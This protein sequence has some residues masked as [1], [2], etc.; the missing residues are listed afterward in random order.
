MTSVI[1][2]HEVGPR[3]GGDVDVARLERM[4]R[5]EIRGEVRFD[6][7]SRALY[8]A[9]ASNYR[10][11]PIGVVIPRDD[12]DVEVAVAA[13]R[14]VGAPVLPRGC[15][16]SLAGQCCNVALI[17]DCSKYMT[18]IRQIDPE[19]KVARV[20][21][22]VRRDQLVNETE[23]HHLTFGPDTSTHKYATIGGMMGNNSCGVRSVLAAFSGTG[24]RAS[25]NLASLDVLTYDGLRLR[26]GPTSDAEYERI[27]REGGRKAE[28]YAGLRA[29]RDRYA[30]QIRERIPDIP[31]RVSGFNLDELLPEKGFNLA[32]AVVGSEGTC[33]TILEA[34]VLLIPSPPERVLLVIG[35][36]DVYQ[37]GDHVPIVMEHRPTGCEGI[38]HELLRYMKL[39]Q[40]H[41][42]DIPLLPDGGGWLL[43]EFGGDTQD[44]AAEKAQGLMDALK[45]QQSSPS[46]RLLR[47][48]EEQADLW[49]IR[50]S[51]LGAT[52]FVPDKHDT[53]PG[54]EDSAVPPDR[55][56][57]YLRDLR[58]L[59]DKYGYDASVYGHFGQGCIH[60]RI[61]FDLRSAAG[62]DK[63]KAFTNEAAELVVHK[64]GGS[65]SGEHGDGQARGE[66]L[67]IMYGDELVSAFREFKAIWDPEGKMNPGKVVD[68]FPRDVNLRLGTDYEPWEPETY[69][70]F[71]DDQGSFSRATLRCVGVGK[72]RRHESGTMCPSFQVLH[73][74]EHTTRGRTHL[75][76][77][78]L[79]GETIT[80]GWKSEPVKEALDLCLAC[81]GCKHDCPVNVDMATYKAEFLAHY[82]EGK[83]RPRSAIAFG[84]IFYW[85]RLAALVPQLANLATHA[86]GLRGLAKYVAGVAPER[87]VPAFAPETFKAW[88]RRHQRE[89]GQAAAPR[90]KVILW[91]DTF[92]NHFHPATAAAAVDVL[93]TAGYAVSVP[94]QWLC[95]GR[96][97]YDYG[98]LKLARKLLQDVLEA[99]R[100]DIRAGV[101][102]IGLEPSCAAVFRDEL[103]NLFP[104]DQDARRLAQQTY[105]LSEFLDSQGYQPPQLKADAIVH[106]HCHHRSLLG[107]DGEFAILERMGLDYR[108][109]DDGC[110]G[111]AGSFGFERG[112][113]YDLSVRRGDQ[114]LLPAVRDADDST[115]IV[116][117]GFSCKEQIEQGSRR[118]GLH[119]AQALQLALRDPSGAGRPEERAAKLFTPRAWPSLAR[120]AAAV[121]AGALAA[122][123]A[124]AWAIKRR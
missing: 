124:V 12:S 38:D 40:L 11:T 45:R 94:Q 73:E 72:C 85:A 48:P 5:S 6:S 42:G 115:L 105:T 123:G 37:A 98:M 59:Y 106:A 118:R 93:E 49:E 22:G 74:E 33:V 80:E 69:F 14:H 76:F 71:P 51:G 122:A 8:A 119:L 99:L 103:I 46:M 9:D 63:Y 19:R 18:D 26:L 13:A 86:P 97:L 108:I 7:G 21:P 57:D 82:Y 64:Y 67:P 43:V 2:E 109:P 95:C 102:L 88:F 25:D 101:P 36:P 61:D 75:L 110:C 83:L 54:W 114:Q 62:I 4:L 68:P 31:R 70:Q 60:T 112:D 1:R 121:G 15:G 96:P 50:E 111:M 20:Q 89:R 30:D 120:S 104:H 77:E 65:L 16:T 3:Q 84:L 107:L 66:L 113:K 56:G 41:T 53:W 29:L 117:D 52:A 17:L 55:V 10:Q 32:R 100:D 116:T 81:K 58:G 92:N 79:R 90:G 39:K 28:I 87:D 91:P 23:R 44:E 47:D 35:Y 24:A 27:V 78:M 34:D